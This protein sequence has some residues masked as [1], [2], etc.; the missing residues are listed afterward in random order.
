MTFHL[1]AAL[2]RACALLFTCL[3]CVCTT[4]AAAL[5]LQVVS[6]ESI[7]AAIDRAAP[8]D[9]IEV[10]YGQ[11]PGRLLIEKPLTLRGVGR[12]TIDGELIA[13]TISVK[14]EN[15]TIEGFIIANSGGDTLHQH[16]G[17]YIYPGSHY[18]VVRHCDFSYTLF[19][20][21]IEKAN[22][23]LI[24]NNIIT[25]KRD[26]SSPKRGNGIQLYNTRYARIIGNNISFVRDAIYVD[27]S[28]D[29]LFRGNKLHHSRYGTHYMTSFRN[30]WEYNDTWN[31]RGGLALMEVRDQIV[32]YNR[33]WGNSD[34]GIMLRTI[35]DSVIENNIVAGNQRGFFIYDAEYNQLRNN[36]IIDNVVGIHLWA[37][38]IN[39]VVEG[40]DFIANREQIRYIA[41]KDMIWGAKVGNYWSNYAGWDRNGDHVGDVPYEAN[42]LID[43]LSW[44][45][46]M[47]KL[48][49]A[50]PAVETLHLVARQFP[51]LRAPSI[52][53]PHP[54]M[55]PHTEEWSQW[56]GKYFQQS[57]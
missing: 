32:R 55:K 15:V 51:L 23:V 14:A 9:T 41:A 53:D 50:S 46:P 11:Y 33:A 8:G 31:N 45:H 48:L 25:G 1:G 37:G 13:N 35:Q 10:A 12:P 52:I 57:R 24:E 54:K 21:W 56:R 5:T 26:F 18:A 19:G 16:A 47:M 28:H 17:I 38:S 27:V 42:D 43:R 4:Q 2:H 6:G 34:H 44:R 30:I 40:N 7:Q 3:L 22:H 39:N 49:L 36:A 29:A 20:L